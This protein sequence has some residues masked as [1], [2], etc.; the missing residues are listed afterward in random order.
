M[1]IIFYKTGELNGSRYVLIPLRTNA[2]LNIESID[3]YC[4]LWSKST[5]LYPCKDDHPSKVKKYRQ[6]FNDLNIEEFDFIHG[7]KF[8]DVHKFEKLNNLSRNIFEINFYQDK[9]KWKHKLIPIE[10]GKK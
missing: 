4:F 2:N 8:S 6:C 3:K 10:I 7:F 9:N 1:K 5:G